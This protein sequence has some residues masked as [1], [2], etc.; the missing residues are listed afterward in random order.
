MKNQQNK[1]YSI[2]DFPENGKTY[3]SFTSKN[4]KKAA[5]QAFTELLRYIDVDKKNGD[6]YMLGKF[7]VFVLQD[8]QNK[9]ENYKYIGTQIKL[10]KPIRKKEGDIE[11]VYYY[12]N[13][14]GDYNS[15]LDNIQ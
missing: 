11:K 15:S 1:T 2:V 8:N 10:K 7:I 13:V 5:S 4:R 9:N 3:G 12:K 6:D 14:I